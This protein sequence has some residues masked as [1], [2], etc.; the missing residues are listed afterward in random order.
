MYGSEYSK[1]FSKFARGRT[2]AP[3]SLRT[4]PQRGSYPRPPAR[5]KIP[6]TSPLISLRFSQPTRHVSGS[7]SAPW[8]TGSRCSTTASH[9]IHLPRRC[10]SVGAVGGLGLPTAP[11]R[12]RSRPA[13]RRG[14]PPTAGSRARHLQG[15]VA[16]R[17]ECPTPFLPRTQPGLHRAFSF[18]QARA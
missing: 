6:R 10:P 5:P 7:T 13:I 18:L 17:H 8:S 4:T 16:G 2:G 1:T 15:S 3:R 12:L 9:G 11:E 14:R